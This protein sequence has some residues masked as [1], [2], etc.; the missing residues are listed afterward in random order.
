MKTRFARSTG[1]CGAGA[2]VCALIF[3]QVAD[4]LGQVYTEPH[5]YVKISVTAGSGTTKKTTLLSLPLLQDP[6]IAGRSSGRIDAI[7][8]G[9]VLCTGAGWV[10]GQLSATEAPH[11]LEITSG[12]AEGRMMLISTETANTSDTIFVDSV[13]V[14]RGSLDGVSVGD[15]FKIRPVDTLSSFFGSPEQTLI[16]G[17]ASPSVADT[18][19]LVV[20]GSA[21]TYFFN[22]AAEPPRWSRVALG[23]PDASNVPIPPYAAIQ[24]SR[25]AN[26]PLEFFAT[27]V[28]PG[29]RRQVAI[30]NSGTTLLSPHWAKERSLSEIGLHGIPGWRKSSSARDADIVSLVTG[31]SA[32]SYFHDGGAWRKITLGL[33]NADGVSVPVGGG[34]LVTRKGQDAGH[35]MLTELA[36]YTL[37]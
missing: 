14:G 26:T 5:G 25:I 6:D 19:T 27:G 20:N 21:S 30:K 7:A 29:G 36:P 33:P 1:I 11:L 15:T 28:V 10:N 24:Y 37:D 22:T 34:V 35:S 2:A 3:L 9:A 32:A 4:T 17:G 23:M 31:G 18:V 13:E 16:A 8:G 12:G